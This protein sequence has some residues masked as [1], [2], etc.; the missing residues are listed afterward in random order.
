MNTMRKLKLSLLLI[1]TITA[2]TMIN[3]QE[4]VES[5]EALLVQNNTLVTGNDTVKNGV[6]AKNTINSSDKKAKKVNFDGIDYYVIDGI[7]YTKFKNKFILKKAPKGAKLTFIPKG[8]KIVTMGGKKYYK[9]NGVF[10]KKVKGGFYEV[11][12]P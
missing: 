6:N 4:K 3:G 2:F 12:R 8:G 7:W 1:C 9:S 11:A 5:Q 10:Y